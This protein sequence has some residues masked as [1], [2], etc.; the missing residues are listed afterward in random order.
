MSWISNARLWHAIVNFLG[1]RPPHYS[2]LSSSKLL[3]MSH[4][5]RQARR[6]R[7]REEATSRNSEAGPS[8][9]TNASGPSQTVTQPTGSDATTTTTSKE[10]GVL[11]ND[12]HGFTE[13]DFIPFE[14]SD[15]EED[16]GPTEDDPFPMREWDK[17][18]G[19]AR[20]RDSDRDYAGAGRKRKVEESELG[21]DD[22]SRHRRQPGEPPQRRAPWV[23]GADLDSCTNVAELYVLP[24]HL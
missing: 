19:K 5:N 14:L 23:V 9:S 24:N 17:G 15:S 11:Q 13:A 4:E 3:N 6:R 7:E 10:N 16:A 2:S 20:E 12:A 1:A 21:R 8:S 22:R 18:K